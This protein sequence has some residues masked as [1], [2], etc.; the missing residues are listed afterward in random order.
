MKMASDVV[1]TESCESEINSNDVDSNDVD[2]YPYP[3]KRKSVLGI[4]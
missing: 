1:V 2:I 4:S 3:G